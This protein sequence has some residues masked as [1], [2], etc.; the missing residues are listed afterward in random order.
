MD[1]VYEQRW[2]P[3]E[4]RQKPRDYDPGV[5]EDIILRLENGEMLPAIC[6]DRDMP[7]PGTFLKWVELDPELEKQYIR[8]R[9]LASEIN[10]DLMVC[11]AQS[12]DNRQADT[13]SRVLGMWAEKTDP[14]RY[15]ARSTVRTKEGNEDGGIDYREE[16][17]RRV[18]AISAKLEQQH[19]D[20]EGGEA[21]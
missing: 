20:E 15:S 14:A 3:E 16:V 17:R 5:A 21:A 4:Y 13:L 10:M 2:T 18:E 12:R 11:A 19:R 1:I 6:R 8:A 9:K 7:L